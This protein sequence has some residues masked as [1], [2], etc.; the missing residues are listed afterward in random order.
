[1]PTIPHIG[2]NATF[3][4][5]GPDRP[6]Q[7]NPE[8]SGMSAGM[9]A[10]AQAAGTTFEVA[11]KIGRKQQQ[12]AAARQVEAESLARAK[13]ANAL[14][15]DETQ[16]DVL[17]NEVGARIADGSLPYQQAEEEFQTELSQR[18]APTFENLPPDDA[19]R[20]QGGLKRNR[21]AGSAKI[22]GL[23]A[24]ARRADFKGQIEAIR[25]KL[26]KVASDPNAD[27]DMIVARGAGLRDF[28][29]EAGVGDT[30]AQD[31]QDFADRV[32]SNNA[33]ARL[34]AGRDNLTALKQ[35]EH[36]LTAKG[37]RYTGHLDADKTNSILSQVLTA[38]GR[39]ESRIQ[40]DADKGEAA[41]QRVLAKF[42][43][44]VSSAVAPP[45][46]TMADW[47]EVMRDGT[48]EQ[49]AQ[50]RELLQGQAQVRAIL[51]EPPAAQRAYVQKLR[52]QQQREGATLADQG[53][54]RRLESA[55]D[56][57]LQQLRESPLTFHAERTGEAIDPLDLQSLMTGDLSAVSAQISER[58]TTLATMRRQYGPEVGN[59]P[60]L[61]QEAAALSGALAQSTPGNA[62]KLYGALNM[63]FDEPAAYRAAMQQ[64]APDSPVRA[65]AGMIYAEQHT[66]TVS[67]GGL[68]GDPV[69]ASSGDV[70]RT[71]L[72]GEAL[73]NRSP[74]AKDSDGK[75]A[76]FPMPSNTEMRDAVAQEVGEVFAGRPRAYETALQAVRAYYAGS[77]SK[78]GDVRGE[79]DTDRVRE[80][81]RAVLGEPV[82]VNG[83]GEVLPPWGMGEEDFSDAIESAWQVQAGSLAEGIPA[84]FDNYG[85]VQAGDG[86]YYVVAAG[87]EFLPTRGGD[88]LRLVVKP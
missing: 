88:P 19:I 46:D 83:N 1:M 63:A 64:I 71:L 32:Y 2:S 18:E 62:M 21:I 36:D 22:G 20:F 42:E 44:Q 48:P 3:G 72:Q 70:A 74:D 29:E 73:L 6:T 78:A 16:I 34:I 35:L 54:L 77:A 75:G 14:L 61:P 5:R 51:R 4:Q 27:L 68:F 30:F 69:K 80:A 58:V 65:L 41:A 79:L 53:N 11:Q 86:V 55:V 7:F 28:A 59:A 17:A 10:L 67:S 81:V 76:A 40:H 43:K 57:N 87:G 60:L 82:D 8:T 50:F 84:E 66:T 38:Q 52:A 12:A 37:G 26:G 47:T 49:Q 23:V 39:I 13:A 85:L 33:K 56:A 25:D 9:N 45:M 31:Q 24:T 15:D